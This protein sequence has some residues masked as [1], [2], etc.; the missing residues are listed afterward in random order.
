MNYTFALLITLS[1]VPNFLFADSHKEAINWADSVFSNMTLEEK[2]GQLFMIAGYS[3]RDANYEQELIGSV[4]KYHPGGVIFFQGD[5]KRQITL[6]NRLQAKSFLPLF[7]G[8]DAEHGLGWRLKDGM[9]FP[10]MQCV[11]AVR[12][13]S[14]QIAI[15]ATIARHLRLVG[16]HINFAPVVDINNNPANPVIGMRSYS[17]NPAIVTAKAHLYA[18][19]SHR[20]GV[21]PV[22]K[23]FPG[24][25]NTNTDSHLALPL[26]YGYREALDSCELVPYR[27]LIPLGLP[28]VMVGHISV[29]ALD[30][31]RLPASIS[32]RIVTGF[33][34]KELRFNGLVFTDAMNMKGV[35][36][37][38]AT[39]KADVEAIAAGNDVILFPESLPIAIEKVKQALRE[40]ILSEQQ[41]NTSCRKILYYK[42]IYQADHYTPI[43]YEE[44]K[45]QLATRQD[46]ALK[47]DVYKSAIT[48]LKNQGE[49]IPLKGLNHAKI[50]C[51]IVGKTGGNTFISTLKRY[52][53]VTSFN[54][55]AESDVA[56]VTS[57]TERLVDYNVVIVYN[58]NASDSYKKAFGFCSALELLLTTQH[59]KTVIVVQPATPYGSSA[60]LDSD[61]DAVLIS[62][63]KSPLA[64][65]YAAQAI[66][67]GISC[68]GVLPVT[69][70][71][72]HPAGSSIQTVK[73]RLGYA[74]PEQIHIDSHQLEAIDSICRRAI[75][76]K[77]TPGCQLLVAKE[78][79]VIY[80]KAFG[81][82]MYEMSSLVSNQTL[83]DI[84]SITKI[85]ATLPAVMQLNEGGKLSLEAKIADYLPDYQTS[86][87]AHIKIVD[88][89]LHQAGLRSSIPFFSNAI[90]KESM[91]AP[92]F[93]GRKTAYNT[94]KIKERLYLN[95][96]FSY[97]DSTFST[98]PRKGYLSIA[99][100]IYLHP[101][102]QDTIRKA[103]VKEQLEK[104]TYRYSDLGFLLLQ[105][106]VERISKQPLDTYCYEAFY[107][108]LG[109]S[110]TLFNPLRVY[111]DKEIAP[112]SEESIYRKC[113]IHG[114]VHD[115]IAALRGGVAGHA[116]LFSTAEDIA[117]LMQ[118][119]LNG[120]EYGG[121]RYFD[122]ETIKRYT[123][124]H[125]PNNR[126]GY[127][128]DKP[129]QLLPQ[130]SPASTM[131]SGASFGHTGFTG[132][133]AWV[134]PTYGLVYVFLSNRTYPNE[135]N[136]ELLKL[137][138]R[139]SIQD[140]IY[141]A[142]RKF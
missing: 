111:S 31:T 101:S 109:M 90:N 64:Q 126:R 43:C 29:P 89:L 95:P 116:G 117:K 91:K 60:I 105:D 17:D 52:A 7:I 54:L 37:G 24:H 63:D 34:K 49:V 94:I 45:S 22:L 102:Y 128:F 110:H 67:G 121:E 48:L 50:A 112:S 28:G 62:Y 119:Y 86:N 68:K 136:T 57:L 75:A 38:K 127:G 4:Q 73:N 124:S 137:N 32:P 39:G 114:T 130:A 53:N 30:S 70:S 13:D 80:H 71:P 79:E 12:D 20:E 122:N 120:G 23:H 104:P 93:S 133:I 19:G 135:Y 11:G 1:I 81:K 33:L 27:R 15:G 96:N 129:N 83:Y 132:T 6:T 65:E 77:A 2:I 76:L 58:N 14:L 139:T 92:L 21:M 56:Q 85:A 26:I 107:S 103:I 123:Q 74:I 36:A 125:L 51:I 115:P 134:D 25:G 88:I 35:T 8:M 5:I 46:S 84:A 72:T 3:N 44:I 140:V 18:R 113:K 69:I 99:P 82:E 141:R 16:V 66:F 78:G 118:L 138:V 10:R 61:P 98:Q 131:A 87:K 100:G 9:T 40:G 142:I 106:V 59:D 42:K 108:R 47:R 55:S 97:K 41:I